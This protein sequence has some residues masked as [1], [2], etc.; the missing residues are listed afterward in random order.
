[1]VVVSVAL[2]EGRGGVAG[3]PLHLTSL[4]SWASLT[5]VSLL[6]RGRGEG[7][8][9]ALVLPE[10]WTL[11]G[12]LAH[13]W[14]LIGQ[15]EVLLV[16]VGSSGEVGGT[17]GVAG[18]VVAW[19]REHGG[20]MEAGPGVE[21]APGARHEPQL[22]HPLLLAPLVLEPDLDHPHAQPRVLGQLLP[23][24][25]RGFGILI[26]AVLEHLK[27]LGLDGCPGPSPPP[28]LALLLDSTGS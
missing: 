4:A 15:A 25:S 13:L 8:E 2:A 1:M 28:V 23:H 24:Q 16:L 27:L 18:V 3:V 26:K 6:G 12:H 22:V 7:A 14:P 19:P 11:I 21:A 20:H 17:G 5:E 9:A 10:Y